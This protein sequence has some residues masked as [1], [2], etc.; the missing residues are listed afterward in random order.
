MGEVARADAV[1]FAEDEDVL[2]GDLLDEGEDEA[3]ELALLVGEHERAHEAVRGEG[4]EVHAGAGA[5]GDLGPRSGEG[6][7]LFVRRHGPPQL[8]LGDLERVVRVDLGLVVEGFEVMRR[9]GRASVPV[10]RVESSVGERD[11]GD[12]ALAQ[13]A[14]EGRQGAEEVDDVL[15]DMVGD[16]E[17]QRLVSE[18]FQVV[19]VVDDVDGVGPDPSKPA[20]MRR[21]RPAVLDQEVRG[22]QLVDQPH[23]R[24][25]RFH[26]GAFRVYLAERAVGKEW[27]CFR[28][29]LDPVAADVLPRHQKT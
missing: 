5:G 13:H 8:A 19:G 20:L 24:R 10:L 18:S 29:D 1:D 3:A 7:G 15:Q 4:V 16:D 2:V 17:I 11:E 14:V 27:C 25:R 28:A 23:G 9:L 26:R 22:R 21:V 6:R 12:P